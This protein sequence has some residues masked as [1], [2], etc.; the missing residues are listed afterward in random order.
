MSD[1]FKKQ[2]G[3]KEDYLNS[4]MSYCDLKIDK[5]GQEEIKSKYY[6]ILNILGPILEIFRHDNKEEKIINLSLDTSIVS[7]ISQSSR[8]YP[9]RKPMKS[10]SP[11][12]SKT[13]INSYNKTELVTDSSK[14]NISLQQFKE[15]LHMSN[16]VS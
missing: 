1:H 4:S 3:D 7:D 16:A 10:S 14:K 12:M 2:N 15:E 9:P 13:S 11:K 8:N 5:F 6:T